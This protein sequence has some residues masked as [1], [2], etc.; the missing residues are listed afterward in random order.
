MGTAGSSFDAR[1]Q[2]RERP[3]PAAGA[4]PGTGNFK[5][6]AHFAPGIAQADTNSRR[7]GFDDTARRAPSRAVGIYGKRGNPRSRTTDRATGKLSQHSARSE[8]RRHTT[9]ANT[10]RATPASP[11]AVRASVIS[12][13][14]PAGHSTS[15]SADGRRKCGNRRGACRLFSS[16]LAERDR[17]LPEFFI[18]QLV[19]RT[20]QGV[21]LPPFTSTANLYGWP[22]PI[23]STSPATTPPASRPL[24]T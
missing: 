18:D 13:R 19:H 23:C 9:R 15:G 6:Y 3:L 4:R 14:T 1:G 11:S 10:H 20:P 7:R 17:W 12:A 24:F 21:E 8:S 5:K 22:A 16:Y 2:C